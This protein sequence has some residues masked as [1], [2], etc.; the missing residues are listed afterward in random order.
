MSADT[1]QQTETE[2][3]PRLESRLV[4]HEEAEARFLKAHLAGKLHHAWILAG[5]KGIGKATLAYRVARFVLRHPRPSAEG[6]EPDSLYVPPE[7]PVFRR[8]ASRAHADLIT[9][10]RRYDPKTKRMKAEI[11]AEE[12]RKAGQFF[13]RTAGEGGWRVCI[14]DAADDMN[15]SAANA[16]LKTLEEP[17]RDAL[18]LLVS[19]VPGWLLPTIRSRCVRLDLAP[20][21]NEQVLDVVRHSDGLDTPPDEATLR[22][23]ADIAE[24]SPGRAI[25]YL[26][27]SGFTLFN[28]FLKLV[29]R[30]PGLDIARALDFAER[31][32]P[33]QALDDYRLFAEMLS[34]WLGGEIR[35]AARGEG[36]WGGRITPA[37]MSRWV[38]AHHAIGHS[39][40]R[41]NALNLDRRQVVMQ[42]FRLIDDTAR[43]AR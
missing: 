36:D 43:A 41:A 30:T 29:E 13:A 17:P 40:A 9:I 39:I 31:L 16:L 1:Q 35:K 21:S 42:A 20:L 25:Q 7:D 34:S 8:V 19:N 10:E 2:R 3:H 6:I 32:K 18:F 27:T 28:D 14:V 37:T 11:G 4:G 33:A 24:G 38:D 15:A 5:P 22:L 26:E 23:A 12:A